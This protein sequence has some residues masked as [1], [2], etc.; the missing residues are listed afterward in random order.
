[1]Y[2]EGGGI[3]GR[4]DD[5]NMARWYTEVTRSDERRVEKT[6]KKTNEFNLNLGEM[7]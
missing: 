6:E 7:Y 4:V 1:M 2:M 3:D 5:Q